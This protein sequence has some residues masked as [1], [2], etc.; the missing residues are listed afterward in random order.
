VDV[1]RLTLGIDS[2]RLGIDKLGSGRSEWLRC[3]EM[4]ADQLGFGML[5]V[6]TEKLGID[7]LKLGTEIWGID[8]LDSGCSEEL[9]CSEKEAEEVGSGCLDWPLRW[10]V[11]AEEV[12]FGCSD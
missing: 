3:S 1:E 5:F 10:E 12:V 7:T 6:G 4:E 11:Y 9:P 8:K 2:D